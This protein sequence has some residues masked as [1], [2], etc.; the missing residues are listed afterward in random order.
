MSRKISAYETT[1]CFAYQ[2]AVAK[3]IPDLKTALIKNQV[4][5][6]EKGNCYLVTGYGNTAN[7]PTFNHPL[8][9][10]NDG[11]IV[12]FVDVRSNVN[13]PSFASSETSYTVKDF[14]EFNFNI[15]R[16]QLQ[17]IWASDLPRLMRDFSTLPLAAY[18]NLISEHTTRRLALDPRDS[19]IITILAGVHYLN[20][21]NDSHSHD[22][23]KTKTVQMSAKLSSVLGI[24]QQLIY[25]IITNHTEISGLDELCVA[26][27]TV[28]NSVRLRDFNPVTL[29][30][31]IGSNW[32]GFNSR[33]LMACSL[34]HPPTWIS[35]ISR[36]LNSRG[37]SNSGLAKF[38][39][40]GMFKRLSVNF[41]NQLKLLTHRDIEY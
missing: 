20:L 41:N 11:K 12:T 22:D 35:L 36:A 16:A 29:F 7:I 38:M 10:E 5:Y 17:Q 1:A 39:E 40:R 15:L 19:L 2:S 3:T 34:E 18:A 26:C 33:E 6:Y 8:T 21:F 23:P 25:E 24:K 27:Q 14:D 13:L 37:Y 30:G 32:Y 28:T 9:F 4:P 31:I